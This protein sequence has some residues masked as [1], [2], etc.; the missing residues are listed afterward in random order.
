M[1]CLS[2][3]P[4]PAVNSTINRSSPCCLEETQQIL[5]HFKIIKKNLASFHFMS[6]VTPRKTNTEWG[7]SELYMLEG[8]LLALTSFCAD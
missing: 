5:F 8:A 4:Q 2:V 7:C 3:E 1:L 6:K